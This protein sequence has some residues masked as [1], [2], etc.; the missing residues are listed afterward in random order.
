MPK[1][2]VAAGIRFKQEAKLCP[3]WGICC[4]VHVFAKILWLFELAAQGRP[5]D[6]S[7]QHPGLT[8]IIHL[9]VMRLRSSMLFP[10][11]MMVSLMFR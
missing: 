7:L 9:G 8:F 4:E 1:E 5:S 6:M 10:V 3:F 2:T 11:S